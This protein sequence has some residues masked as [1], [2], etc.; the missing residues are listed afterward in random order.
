MYYSGPLLY[1]VD[2][3]APY[4]SRSKGWNV[5][6]RKV[7][8]SERENPVI[9]IA[10]NAEINTKESE[11]DWGSQ[12]GPEVEDVAEHWPVERRRMVAAV[13]RPISNCHVQVN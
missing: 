5:D 9:K 11:G 8:V 1:T 4:R 7:V 3:G 10:E 6:S 13:D 2:P 12:P